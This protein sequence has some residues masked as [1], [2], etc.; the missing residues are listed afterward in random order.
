M[1]QA[2]EKITILGRFRLLRFSLRE[3]VELHRPSGSDIAGM[4]RLYAVVAAEFQ[5][6]VSFVQ[7]QSVLYD[8]RYVPKHQNTPAAGAGRDT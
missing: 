3:H 7:S 1:L 6:L 8:G 5:E 2:G 4:E